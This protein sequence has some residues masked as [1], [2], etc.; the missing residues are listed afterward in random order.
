MHTDVHHLCRCVVL[1]QADLLASVPPWH[2]RRTF[3]QYFQL[4][5][6]VTFFGVPRGRAA[7]VAA[8]AGGQALS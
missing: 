6:R 4:P 8:T 2:R 5:Q 3:E 7:R 1:Q